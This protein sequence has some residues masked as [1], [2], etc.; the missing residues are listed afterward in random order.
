MLREIAGFGTPM[1]LA[2]GA[3]TYAEIHETVN[4]LRPYG[5]PL[6][7]LHCTL[8][9]PTPVADANLQ[10]IMRLTAEFPDLVI[11][12]SDHVQPQDTELSCPLAVALGARIVEKH[13]TLN[14]ALP[15]DDHYHAVDPA[16]L[17]RLV[18]NCRDAARMTG[19][20]REM[21]ESETPARTYARRSIVAARA[22]TAGQVLTKADLDYKRPGTGLS[23]ARV[24]EVLGKRL[25]RNLEADAL[26]L[27]EDV[28]D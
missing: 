24:D 9:Y 19:A 13:F 14:K 4:A 1:L 18:A 7:L 15:D 6:A 5:I 23:P 11:G 28:K 22:L 26:V 20:A 2:T 3:A 17:A 12:Y 16:G 27:L 10:R 8:A 25:V 21:T